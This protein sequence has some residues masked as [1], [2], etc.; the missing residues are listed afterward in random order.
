MDKAYR[1]TDTISAVI[2]STEQ[3]VRQFRK[4]AAKVRRENRDPAKAREFLLRAGIIEKHK[5]SPNGVRLAK[6]FR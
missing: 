2:Q 6:R 4:A 3:T 5:G 1:E